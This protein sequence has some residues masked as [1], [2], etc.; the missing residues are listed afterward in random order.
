LVLNLDASKLNTH[1]PAGR[2]RPSWFPPGILPELP[3]DPPP[4]AVTSAA[5]R[6]RSPWRRPTKRSCS[7][8]AC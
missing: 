3:R 8:V 5:S 4:P 2:P 7:H 1:P 6:R